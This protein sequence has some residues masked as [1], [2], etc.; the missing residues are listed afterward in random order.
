MSFLSE[1]KLPSTRFVLPSKGA[2][3]TVGKELKQT[4]V[5]GEVSIRPYTANDEI[6]LLN[7]DS[8][9]SGQAINEVFTKR[10][11]EILN[12][13]ELLYND[14]IAIMTYF[15][16]VTYGDKFPINTKH[17][18]EHAQSHEVDLSLS[19]FLKNK[20]RLYDPTINELFDMKLDDQVGIKFHPAIYKD[21]I[22]LLGKSKALQE[23]VLED[24]F[25]F[26]T[27]SIMVYTECLYN[28]KDPKEIITDKVEIKKF[29]T[30]SLPT[31]LTYDIAKRI[32]E[33]D[34]L[35]GLDLIFEVKCKDCKEKYKEILPID[36]TYFFTS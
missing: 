29:I 33:I 32:E 14:V 30:D 6:H 24:R 9:I 36:F 4:L 22:A 8:I 17:D 10:I 2:F 16:L 21:K 25:D 19:E 1:Y 23:N 18:C 27:E 13:S 26:L 7:A 31:T 20:I 5:D 34:K 12:P 3:Y 11:D 28:I 15:R 35:I